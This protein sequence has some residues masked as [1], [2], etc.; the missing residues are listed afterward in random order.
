MRISKPAMRSL[1]TFSIGSLIYAA[2]AQVHAGDF[3]QDFKTSFSQG[4][5]SHYHEVENDSMLLKR[6][7]RFYTNDQHKTQQNTKQDKNR[8]TLFGWRLGQELYTAW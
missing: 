2:V 5:T 3:I 1:L 7:D 6:D 4:K 8:M